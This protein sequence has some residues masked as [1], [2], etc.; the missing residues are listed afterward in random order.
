MTTIFANMKMKVKTYVASGLRGTAIQNKV[1]LFSTLPAAMLVFA[2]CHA[3]D[4]SLH[5]KSMGISGKPAEALAP[6]VV[7]PIL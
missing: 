2:G 7:P 5:V 3:T 4:L 1:I 6:A